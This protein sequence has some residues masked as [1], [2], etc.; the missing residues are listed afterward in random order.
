MEGSEQS[1]S[2]SL[3]NV[4]D[5][6]DLERNKQLAGTGLPSTQLDEGTR[7]SQLLPE[8]KKS[9]PKDSVG[10]NQPIDTGFPFMDSDKG[11]VKTMLLPKGPPGEKDSERLI[12]AADM[13]P[14][15]NPIADPL[16]T[17]AK[18]HVDE[19]Q[20]TRL[21][22]VIMKKCLQLERRWM[23]T[24]HLQMDEESDSDSSGLEF[25]KYDSTLPLTKRKLVKASIERYYEENVDH[26]DQTI[27]LVQAT[28]DC[29]DKNSI[30]RAD[31]LK[32]LN[33]VTETLKVVQ[34]AIKDDHPLNRM[35]IEATE[36]YTKNSTSLVRIK[37]V[38][39]ILKLH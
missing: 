34:E 3:G 7:K 15:T 24:S 5:P 14:L 8:G 2:V 30:E 33:E 21:R 23:K 20:S 27:K 29:L 37:S 38:V 19:T 11:T 28:M 18:Y 32:A 25:K 6:Q 39:S 31:L 1:H 22:K 35:I 26:K 16:G 13:E 36:S 17:G 10:N 4:H 12:P 9:D